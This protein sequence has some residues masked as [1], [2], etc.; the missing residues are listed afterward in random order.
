MTMDVLDLDQARNMRAAAREGRNKPLP[1]R[2][3]GE[4][5]ATLPVEFPID[6]LEP[7]TDV[8][9]DL[10]VVVSHV[11]SMMRE[12]NKPEA[13]AML[14]ATNLVIDVLAGSPDLPTKFV[15]VIKTV[16]QRLLGEDG[17]RRFMAARPSKD[18]VA[19]FAKGVMQYYGVSL[20][21]VLRSSDSST[22]DGQTSSTTSKP[23]STDST[24]EASGPNQAPLAS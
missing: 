14:E 17:A 1:I 18:D 8:A 6:V 24:P 12:Q 2:I 10:M 5:I 19:A 4:E 23:T 11:M 20:G 7:L 16:G 9:D 21:E 13:Q 22:S 15:G 3:G